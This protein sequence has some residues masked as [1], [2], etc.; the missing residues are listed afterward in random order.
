MKLLVSM[1]LLILIS[2]GGTTGGGSGSVSST[3]PG[4]S[5]T[6]PKGSGYEN[7]DKFKSAVANNQW[8]QNP[9]FASYNYYKFN[10]RNP[11]STSGCTK[12]GSGIFSFS[13][14]LNQGTATPA[15]TTEEKKGVITN[16][17]VSLTRIKDIVSKAV[18]G[19]PYLSNPDPAV[20]YA[21]FDYTQWII[22]F[23]SEIFAFNPGYPLGANPTY[24]KNPAGQEF[25]LANYEYS[26]IP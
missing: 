2:C 8:A 21:Y 11:S 12:I 1:V 25:S 23:G 20:V 9:S 6:Y 24:Y 16:S 5:I 17:L 7:L 4:T 18:L 14:C 10:Y 15:W 3:T 26:L 22:K 13:Y 19:N